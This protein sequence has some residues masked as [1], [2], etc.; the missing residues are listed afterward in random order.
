MV[1]GLHSAG[2]MERESTAVSRPGGDSLHFSLLPEG[3]M[4][5]SLLSKATSNRAICKSKMDLPYLKECV[6]KKVQ[7]IKLIPSS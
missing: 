7:N 3:S 1:P 5:F 6:S 2:W 4:F